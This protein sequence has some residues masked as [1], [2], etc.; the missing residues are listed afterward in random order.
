MT[1]RPKH[2]PPVTMKQQKDH[3]RQADNR[4]TIRDKQTTERPSETRRQQTLRNKRQQT[5][6]NKET[7]D[8]QGQGDNRHSG[9]RRQQTFRDKETTDL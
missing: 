2:I 4:K 5:L 6:R 3:Q 9:I 1:R 7:T 8:F